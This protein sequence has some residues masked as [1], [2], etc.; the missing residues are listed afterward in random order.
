MVVRFILP[1]QIF[2]QQMKHHNTNNK[3]VQKRG[4]AHVQNPST[5]WQREVHCLICS[6]IY[7]GITRQNG[8]YVLCVRLFFVTKAYLMKTNGSQ[9]VTL[10]HVEKHFCYAI[11]DSDL[12]NNC[13]AWRCH[14]NSQNNVL[15][16]FCLYRRYCFP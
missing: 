13:H 10:L 6:Y 3:K 2:V 9:T 8:L 11:N 14:V 15:E 4:H 7:I 12:P 1:N 5:T 16:R